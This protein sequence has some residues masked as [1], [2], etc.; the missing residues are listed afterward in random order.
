MTTGLDGAQLVIDRL[1][2]ILEAEDVAELYAMTMDIKRECLRS[3][4]CVCG[5]GIAT[6]MRDQVYEPLRC[7]MVGGIRHAYCVEC[8]FDFGPVKEAFH[9]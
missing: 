6:E 8:D 4:T 3:R 1:R 5:G 7:K 2:G 9:A